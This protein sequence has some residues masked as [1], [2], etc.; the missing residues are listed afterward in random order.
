MGFTGVN[1][2]PSS[3]FTS[4]SAAVLLLSQTAY[5][6]RLHLI[7]HF[8]AAKIDFVLPPTMN[9]E[10]AYEDPDSLCERCQKIDFHHIFNETIDFDGRGVVNLGVL[11]KNATCRL[12]RFFYSVRWHQIPPP[13]IPSFDRYHLRVFEVEAWKYSFP[14]IGARGGDTVCSVVPGNIA[15]YT[16]H[17]WLACQSDYCNMAGVEGSEELGTNGY[18]LFCEHPTLSGASSESNGGVNGLP[19]A[20]IEYRVLSHSIN[21]PVIKSWLTQCQMVGPSPPPERPM[22]QCALEIRCIDCESSE[23]VRLPHEEEYVA[24]SYVWGG[25]A[26]VTSILKEHKH[27]GPETSVR[28]FF[29]SADAPAVIRDAITA[30][31]NMGLRYLWV[32]QCCIDQTDADDRRVQVK[33]MDRIYEGAFVTI[34]AAAGQDSSFGLPG[35]GGR[36]RREQSH[37]KLTSTISLAGSLPT[38]HKVIRESVWATRGWTYQEAVLSRR[39]L[40]F[41]DYQVYFVCPVQTWSEGGT[42]PRHTSPGSHACRPNVLQ[43]SRIFADD[44]ILFSSANEDLRQVLHH[45]ERYSTRHLTNE[46]DA[47]DALRGLMTRIPFRTY[48]GLVL[49]KEVS[50]KER[51]VQEQYWDRKTMP[52]EFFLSLCFAF[53]YRQSGDCAIRRRHGFPSWSWLGWKAVKG[54]SYVNYDQDCT[55]GITSELHMQERATFW[56]EDSAGYHLPMTDLRPSTP[57]AISVPFSGNPRVIPEL[58][59]YLWVESMVLQLRFHEVDRYVVGDHFYADVT[60]QNW[61]RG[62]VVSVYMSENYDD[63]QFQRLLTE[64]WDCLLLYRTPANLSQRRYAWTFLMLEWSGDTAYRVGTFTILEKTKEEYEAFLQSVPHSVRKIRLG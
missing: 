38:A 42:Y 18:F 49:G 21:Y 10:T 53:K 30:V 20:G 16:V 61:V 19:R 14:F 63:P 6:S 3:Y 41:T 25:G 11:D 54:V 4:S 17:T 60:L 27:P 13:G 8:R 56:A 43:M 31:K 28:R 64:V 22:H 9:F 55:E 35:V 39:M 34:V 58:S 5:H 62:R 51:E 24:L 45:L 44:S 47:L 26:S 52:V 7:V 23:V 1:L 48:Y 29:V 36:P 50:E 2:L 46:E 33:N 59:T 32:D 40:I 12:C 57:L 15:E 37:V